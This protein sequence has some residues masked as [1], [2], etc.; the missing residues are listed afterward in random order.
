MC[1][2]AQGVTFPTPPVPQRRLLQSVRAKASAHRWGPWLSWGAQGPV[3]SWDGLGWLHVSGMVRCLWRLRVKEEPKP[4]CSV[5]LGALK[6]ERQGRMKQGEGGREGRNKSER[7][8]VVE[9]SLLDPPRR[10]HPLLWAP[11]PALPG[12]FPSMQE[13]LP[14][15]P[16]CVDTVGFNLDLHTPEGLRGKEPRFSV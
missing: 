3:S 2:A 12:P 13:V 1:A 7:P 5:T 9:C 14:F 16:L 8:L 10:N 11:F 6:G 4:I 15:T